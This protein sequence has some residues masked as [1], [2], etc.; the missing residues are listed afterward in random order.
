MF[1]SYSIASAAAIATTIRLRMGQ[2][3]AGTMVFNGYAGPTQYFGGV[4]ASGLTV[5]EVGA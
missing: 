5:I 4:T 1:L 3:T 2:N